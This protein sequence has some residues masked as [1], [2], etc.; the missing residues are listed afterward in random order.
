MTHIKTEN[1]HN[2]NEEIVPQT[3]TPQM[4][5]PDE[6]GDGDEDATVGATPT[7]ALR[8]RWADL[9]GWAHAQSTSIWRHAIHRDRHVGGHV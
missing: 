2:N 3:P 9:M 5:A 1:M 6:L 4:R 8:A 7:A